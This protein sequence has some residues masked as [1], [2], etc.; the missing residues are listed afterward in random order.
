MLS[1]LDED[2]SGHGGSRRTHGPG[3]RPAGGGGT[4]PRCSVSAVRKESKRV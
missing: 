3:T 4:P 2:P 1:L